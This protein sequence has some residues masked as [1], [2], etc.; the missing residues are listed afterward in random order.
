VRIPFVGPA[1]EARSVRLS[2]QRCVNLYL[3][4]APQ[5]GKAPAMLVPTPGLRL[6]S[7]MPTGNSVQGMLN[8]N[9]TL[10]VVAGGRIYVAAPDGSALY[11]GAIGNPTD[12]V[13]MAFN[14]TQLCIVDGYGGYIVN[15]AV[16]PGSGTSLTQITDPDFP[17]GVTQVAYLDGYFI[18]GAN[19][20]G[21]FWISASYNGLSWNGL[22]FGVAEGAAD[23]IIGLIV[24]HRELWLIG[25]SSA[26]VWTNTG[27]ASFPIERLPNA[28]IE[29][30]IAAGRSLAK[31]DN[32]VFWLSSNDDGDG[33]VFRANGYL[34]E[35]ISTHAVESAIKQYPRID[36][37]IAYTY[38]DA[39]HA[40]YLLSFPSGGTTWVFDVAS[41][42][43]HERQY[44]DA[45]TGALGRHRGQVHAF[46]YRKH[47]VGD[48]ASGRVYELSDS[49]F[50]DNGDPIIRLR[51]SPP[52]YDGEDQNLLFF[53][54]FQLDFD[55]GVGLNTGQGS[56]PVILMRY[57]NDGGHSWSSSRPA[58]MGRGGE[59]GARAKWERNGYGRVR[60]WEVSWSDPV[61]GYVMGATVT[62]VKG[63][64]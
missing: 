28:F 18:V 45:S 35:R 19:G 43:W 47:L 27:A 13:G 64:A 10:Y 23:G 60:C 32:T 59:Y 20:T 6:F 33:M 48:Y 46:C 42:T 62:A 5:G 52:Q 58:T 17:N 2:A 56:A 36:D 44:R 4:T 38:Q 30:G 53:G 9:G 25:S 3:E 34:P 12:P 8:A 31:L 54:R 7:T 40:F 22:D 24:D 37:A 16:L 26:E 50:T 41:G 29:H 1:Y 63:T 49:T 14:G 51:S 15:T 39:G 11:V 55:A 21:R 61:V 57:S